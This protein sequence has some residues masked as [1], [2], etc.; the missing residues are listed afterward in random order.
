MYVDES[1][2]YVMR[3]YRKLPTSSNIYAMKKINGL[4]IL[5]SRTLQCLA[6]N[7]TLARQ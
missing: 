4:K 2:A 1:V 3:F 6:S 5:M 7:T